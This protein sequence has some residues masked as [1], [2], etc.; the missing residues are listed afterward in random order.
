MVLEF[1][2]LLA[3]AHDIN[4]MVRTSE[5]ALIQIE[6]AARDWITHINEAKTWYIV[7]TAKPNPIILINEDKKL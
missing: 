7:A 1:N 6:Q 2:K 4:I 3:Y 5:D